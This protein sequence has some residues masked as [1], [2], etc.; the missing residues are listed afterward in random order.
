[1]ANKLNFKFYDGDD[2]HSEG[3]K[4]IMSQGKGLNDEQR[5][6]WLYILR[7]LLIT[8][9][10]SNQSVVLACSA[11]K[12]KYR[13]FLNCGEMFMELNRDK[14]LI[15]LNITFIWLQCDYGVV[16]GRLKARTNHE[17]V[18][19][20]AQFLKTQ[21]EASEEPNENENTNYKC[22][23]INCNSFKTVDECSTK[24]INLLK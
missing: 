10:Q 22:I 6:D 9:W 12:Q 18:K 24:I 21:F 1:L 19:L 8:N 13:L 11:L 23:I 7:N 14:I 17:I 5:L 16:E 15:K 4:K 3:N 2:Y 20:P